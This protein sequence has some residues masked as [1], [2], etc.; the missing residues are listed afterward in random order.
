M[1]M[2][3]SRCVYS[4]VPAQSAVWAGAA[5]LGGGS[6]RVSPPE[7]EPNRRRTPASGSCPYAAVDSAQVC[8]SPGG[9]ISEREECDAPGAYVWGTAAEFCRRALLGPRL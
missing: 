8:G 5:V 2:Q 7:G 1:G 4:E 9:R 6:S 3:I